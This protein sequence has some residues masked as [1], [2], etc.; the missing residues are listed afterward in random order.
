MGNR[1]G[2]RMWE[3]ASTVKR[4]RG[5][6]STGKRKTL[7][8]REIRIDYTSSEIEKTTLPMWGCSG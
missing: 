1:R 4:G 2:K 5:E 8:S 7:L 6:K 3:V